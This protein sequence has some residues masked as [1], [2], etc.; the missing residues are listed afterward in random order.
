V[1]VERRTLRVVEQR[2]ADAQALAGCEEDL[3]GQPGAD[4]VDPPEHRLAA[5]EAEQLEVDARAVARPHERQIGDAE[6]GAGQIED[7]RLALDAP[8]GVGALEGGDER[9][10]LLGPAAP[11]SVAGAR[12]VRDAG[13]AHPEAERAAVGAPA[14]VG[15]D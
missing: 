11:A 4:Q 2:L 1:N 5:P 8:A 3:L 9:R 10:Q 14:H 7:G 12:A 6:A 13:A 15:L